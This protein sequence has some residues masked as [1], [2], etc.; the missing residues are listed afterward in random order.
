MGLVDELSR[1]GIQV[2]IIQ[3]KVRAFPKPLITDEVRRMIAENRAALV[4]ELTSIEAGLPKPYFGDTGCLAIPFDSPKRYHW[5]AGGQPV[6]ETMQEMSGA[7]G[8]AGHS[9]E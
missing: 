9:E 6:K 4:D 2:W 1:L 7:N 8:N 5:W 3:D